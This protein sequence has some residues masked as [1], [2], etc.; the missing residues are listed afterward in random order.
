MPLSLPMAPQVR[1]SAP[2]I[3]LLTLYL[4][5]CLAQAAAGIKDVAD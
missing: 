4:R 3:K 1:A 5:A 2:R